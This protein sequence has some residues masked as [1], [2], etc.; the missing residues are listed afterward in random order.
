MAW[1]PMPANLLGPRWRL[2]T[3]GIRS[4]IFAMLLERLPAV[5]SLAPEEKWLL[6]DELWLEL[7]QQVESVP[8]DPKIVE[9][10]EQRFNQYLADSS[11]ASPVDAVFARLA[12][13]KKAWK[14]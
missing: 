1:R 5:Q 14:L 12:E 10:L 2:A 8:A 13:R 4:Y 11:Q 3:L 6:I 9:L 7:A